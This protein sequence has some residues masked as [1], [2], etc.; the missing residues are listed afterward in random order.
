MKVHLEKVTKE[1]DD[2]KSRKKTVAVSELDVEIPSGKLIGLLGPSGCGKSTTLYMIA[3]IHVVSSG[4]IWFDDKD[5]TALAPEKRGVGMVFQNYALYPH[6]NVYDN[7]AF[8]IVNSKDMKR[9]FKEELAE[10]NKESGKNLTF[11]QYVDMQVKAVAELVEIQEYMGRKPSELSGGQQQR[12]AIARALVKKPQLLLLDEPLSNL[13]ARLRLQ[14]REEIKR[15]QKKTG[16]TTIFVTHDQ[17]EAM[18]ICD[19]IVVMKK[20]VLQQVGNPQEVFECPTNQFVAE[21]LGTPPINIIEGEIKDGVLK[22]G[23]AQWKH[24]PEECSD[25]PVRIGLRAENLRISRDMEKQGVPAE[26]CEVSKQ[27]GISMVTAKMADGSAVKIFQDIVNPV[28]P[29]D[30][31]LLWATENGTLVFDREGRK[32]LQW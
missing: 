11:K 17:E 32:L 21:F 3:G 26:V 18:T 1:F 30:S 16:I 15:L 20:G 8:P 31:I 25:Q 7:I 13:D 24:I 29:G 12:V 22:M 14:T 23:N 6:L 4:T 27:G 5:V 9:R 28:V 10:Y 19:Q 2:K